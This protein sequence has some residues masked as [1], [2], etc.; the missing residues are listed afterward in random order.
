MARENKQGPSVSDIVIVIIIQKCFSFLYNY[1][2][3]DM[4]KQQALYIKRLTNCCI[5]IIS[6]S[7]SHHHVSI[8]CD[9]IN[10]IQQNCSALQEV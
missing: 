10:R 5:T 9:K 1:S 4:R 7:T 8:M 6:S 2:A 3:K